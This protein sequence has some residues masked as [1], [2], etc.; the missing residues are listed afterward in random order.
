M[1]FRQSK[2]KRAATPMEEPTKDTWYAEVHVAK[3][4]HSFFKRGGVFAQKL[5]HDFPDIQVAMPPKS[6]GF[7]ISGDE[8]DVRQVIDL[9]Q[10]TV[11][12]LAVEYVVVPKKNGWK[13]HWCTRKTNP[14][15]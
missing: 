10:R 3:M 14:V 2:P 6:E 13:G 7:K 11:E 5:R 8:I 12:S 15:L 1:K 4:Y 9:I